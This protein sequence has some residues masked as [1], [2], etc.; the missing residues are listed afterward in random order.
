MKGLV[1]GFARIAMLFDRQINGWCLQGIAQVAIM[2]CASLGAMR[3]V[4]KLGPA[5]E[6]ALL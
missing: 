6:A 3:I 5:N 1:L 4:V 2:S